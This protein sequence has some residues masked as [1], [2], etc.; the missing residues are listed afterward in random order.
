MKPKTKL[1]CQLV[2]TMPV[3]RH[4]WAWLASR[5]FDL[6]AKPNAA[7]LL[8]E[9]VC[10]SLQLHVGACAT[11]H[12]LMAGLP[13]WKDAWILAVKEA[14]RWRRNIG[15]PTAVGQQLIAMLLL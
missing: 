1:Q 14:T 6:L 10:N 9:A 12:T 5:A 4:D 3:G 2:I 8:E 11:G 13:A 15:R 7:S